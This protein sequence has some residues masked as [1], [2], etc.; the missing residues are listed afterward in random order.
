MPKIFPCSH[1]HSGKVRS[2]S[3][4]HLR[5]SNRP[6]CLHQQNCEG[7]GIRG[8]SPS[9]AASA[10]PSCQHQQESYKIL[11]SFSSINLQLV[12]FSTFFNLSITA[13]FSTA[14]WKVRNYTSFPNLVLSLV[15]LVLAVL[16][17]TKWV[18]ANNAKW[19]VGYGRLSAS[20]NEVVSV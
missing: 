4:P 10:L 11:V 7:A 20:E 15:L 2:V 8:N 3:D 6:V 17:I 16:S 9:L 13:T 19:N 14:V 5:L 1:S 12:L 18:T